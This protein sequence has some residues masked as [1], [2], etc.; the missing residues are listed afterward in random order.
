MRIKT[1]AEVSFT[2]PMGLRLAFQEDFFSCD[3]AVLLFCLAFC[4]QSQLNN[5]ACTLPYAR[6]MRSAALLLICIASSAPPRL[7][8]HIRSSACTCLLSPRGL[9][10]MPRRARDAAQYRGTPGGHTLSVR[11]YSA[12]RCAR[13]FRSRRAATSPNE[14]PS[15]RSALARN[16]STVSTVPRA[17]AN[18]HGYMTKP[19]SRQAEAFEANG[20]PNE[21]AVGR[22][23]G[24]VRR[25][26][27]QR[28]DDGRQLGRARE[29]RRGA[30]TISTA[31]ERLRPLFSAR[32]RAN[33]PRDAF[34]LLFS[35]PRFP[36]SCKTCRYTHITAYSA[37]PGPSSAAPCRG[38]AGPRAGSCAAP[39]R[40]SSSP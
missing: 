30:L 17:G 33:A 16:A 14:R 28:P 6:T 37:C 4:K 21:V 27:R 40:R 18:G 25:P 9:S 32:R 12:N 7:K 35:P 31:C 8:K 11:S 3:A 20:W 1:S 13:G 5:S 34:P 10:S 26:Q 22:Q 24:R 15:T 39:R 38:A 23:R 36:L 29:L 19:K 2:Q